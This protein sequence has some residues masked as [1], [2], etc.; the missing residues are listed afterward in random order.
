M[1]PFVLFSVNKPVSEGVSQKKWIPQLPFGDI[2]SIG[3][4]DFLH[5]Q[6]GKDTNLPPPSESSIVWG[7][8]VGWPAVGDC[9]T[10]SLL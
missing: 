1:E 4:K 5:M 8:A 2:D 6:A 7:G 3:R 9:V 10:P